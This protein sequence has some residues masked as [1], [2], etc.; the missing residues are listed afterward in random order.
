[1]NGPEFDGW[2]V[3]IK[4]IALIFVVIGAIVAVKALR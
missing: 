1:M 3:V 4:V 2:K